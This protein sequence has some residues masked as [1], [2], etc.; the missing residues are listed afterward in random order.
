M[1][2]FIDVLVEAGAVACGPLNTEL[3]PERAGK[4]LG[5][6]R[7]LVVQRMEDGRLPF[8]Y[9]GTHWRCK[10]TD[11]LTLKN[12]E[13]EQNSHLA[14]IYDDLMDVDDASAP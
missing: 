7:P 4:I 9:V 5:V 11:V 13:A 1:K 8:H 2:E 3:R 10:L 6:P 14:R 12:R